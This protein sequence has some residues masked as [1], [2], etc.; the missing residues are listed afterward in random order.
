MGRVSIFVLA[1]SG[2]AVGGALATGPGLAFAT[3]SAAAR[4]AAA[5]APAWETAQKLA[6]AP[7]GDEDGAESGAVLSCSSPG[8]CAVAGNYGG[9]A[10]GFSPT[11]FVA[12]QRNGTWG[13]VIE[14]P[15]LAAL[16]VGNDSGIE[17][18][19][20]ASAGNCTAGGDYSPGGTDAGGASPAFDAFAV[21]EKAGTWGGATEVP[22]TAALN[23]GRSAVVTSVSCWSAG[24]CTAAGVYA[25]G[26]V[27]S[28]IVSSQ[29]FVVTEKNGTWGPATG[30]PGLAALNTGEQGAADSM[31][32]TA[33]ANCAVGGYY[34]TTS[35]QQE[36]FVADESAGAWHPAE[37]VP[38][39]GALNPN[40]AAGVYG[41]SCASAGNCGAIGYAASNS[42]EAFLT[43]EINGTWRT[44]TAIPGAINP[45]S[46]SCP[47]AGNCV[48]GGSYLAGGQP[49]QG[50]QAFVMAEHNGTWGALLP[51]P[52]LA[53]L[54]IGQSAGIES[55]SC[56]APG[57]CGAGGYYAA[58]KVTKIA[59]P[60]KR[61]EPTKIDQPPPA[62]GQAFVVT[63]T[64][65]IWGRAEAV[66][67]SSALAAPDSTVL[68][69]VSCVSPQ[70]CTATGVYG[71]SGPGG[72]FVVSTKAPTATTASLSARRVT[73]GD[74]Q[75]ERVSAAVTAQTG[76]LP[77]GQV[78]VKAGSATVCVIT[79]RSGRG[80]CT[81][82][83][84]RLRRGTYSL[85]AAYPGGPGS[86]GSV[87][88]AKP[89]TVV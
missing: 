69:A 31:S 76:A 57:D 66:P 87:S 30:L 25:P 27:I 45:L 11:A 55:M 3:A 41:I 7:K 6:G 71:V 17:T 4:P 39:S 86:V 22:G 77:A 58:K 82:T 72:I 88:R 79:L 24:D 49:S 37:E 15:G 28:G 64:D 46:I 48:A 70:A 19:S 10:G 52:G 29:V 38:G 35:G 60:A 83:A 51:V 23:T 56:S 47:S 54:N 50:F 16:N 65:G 89:L 61:A 44:A 26:G 68:Y 33:G 75:A 78:A 42:G 34:T 5:A 1:V 43:S 18:L 85:T 21:T 8:N 40:G 12:N 73:Y 81:L 53:G 62:P 9:L 32:C 80:S 36:A 84:R 20:C 59:K 2:V 74:E 67:G 13:T 63:E 14:V